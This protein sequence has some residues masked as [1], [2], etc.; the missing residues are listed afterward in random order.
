MFPENPRW[1]PAQL[2]DRLGW[3]KNHAYHHFIY[4]FLPVQYTSAIQIAASR[5]P[6]SDR[7]LLAG[8]IKCEM[9]PVWNA[10]YMFTCW[11]SVSR[12]FYS[13]D[14]FVKY[15]FAYN[16][17]IKFACFFVFQRN[18]LSDIYFE[19]RQWKVQEPSMKRKVW[20]R[21]CSHSTDWQYKHIMPYKRLLLT[22]TDQYEARHWSPGLFVCFLCQQQVKLYH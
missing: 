1:W 9:I 18:G 2:L 20:W 19:S 10:C 15:V 4:G 8:E 16:S 17:Q 21:D 11:Y 14:M 12:C 3:G 13:W 6:G 22:P 5:L 7:A